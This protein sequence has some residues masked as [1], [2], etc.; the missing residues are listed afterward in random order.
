M[1]EVAANWY[2]NGY[3]PGVAAVDRASLR[4]GAAALTPTIPARLRSAVQQ[5]AKKRSR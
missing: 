1:E 2:D 3:L 4:E 5:D